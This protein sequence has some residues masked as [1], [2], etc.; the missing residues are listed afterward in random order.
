MVSGPRPSGAIYGEHAVGLIEP[1]SCPVPSRGFSGPCRNNSISAIP[2]QRPQNP[3]NSAQPNST[4]TYT[5]PL[6]QL[7]HLLQQCKLH[8]HVRQH[9]CRHTD[10][11]LKHAP[12]QNTH[13]STQMTP[14]LHNET[15]S[16]YVK[17]QPHL[18]RCDRPKAWPPSIEY[19]RQ[20]CNQSAMATAKATA[21]ATSTAS[22]QKH[23]VN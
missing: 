13:P 11:A 12:Q 10:V 19:R 7:S 20:H 18:V 23:N 4:A 3:S 6:S 16:G 8:M 22:L 21:K 5:K 2:N 1:A 9:T 15:L 17:T 14:T